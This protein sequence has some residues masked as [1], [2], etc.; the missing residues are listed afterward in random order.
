MTRGVV[1][2]EKEEQ[3]VVV[4]FLEVNGLMFS[5]TAQSTYTTSPKQKRT[6][7]QM[8]VR[9]GLPDLIIHIP[10]SKSADKKGWIVFLEMKRSVKS[11]SKV[12]KEQQAW[13]N[14]ANDSDCIGIIGYGATDA[15]EQLTKFLTIDTEIF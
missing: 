2:I 4:D 11:L 3:Q 8:G 12:S 15:L 6:N 13:V 1:P 7:Y 14:A 9:P 5:A 10:P